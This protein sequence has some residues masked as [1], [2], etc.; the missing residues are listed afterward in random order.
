MNNVFQMR[1]VN[2]LALRQMAATA[3][4]NSRRHQA[5]WLAAVRYLRRRRLWICD[6]ARATWGVPGEAA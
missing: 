4:P 3:H 6:G 5:R 1:R 2:A